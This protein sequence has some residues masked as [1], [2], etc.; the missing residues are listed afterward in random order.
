[1]T[2]MGLDWVRAWSVL[3]TMSEV[4]LV[5]VC[6]ACEGTL[7]VPPRHL[8]ATGTC[9]KCGVR[10]ALI[11]RA[12]GDTPQRASLVA[13]AVEDDTRIPATEKQLTYL[14]ALGARPEALTGLTRSR[15]SALIEAGKQRRQ[16]GEPATERQRAYLAK[17]GADPE[18][19]RRA[20]TK[21]AASALIEDMH[22]HPT[23]PQVDR[24]REL[25]ATGAQ[26]AALKSRGEVRALLLR[27]GD[28]A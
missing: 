21:A 28:E 7:R 18:L 9:N 23:R 3:P 20:A 1:M 10:I 22:L 11:G 27:L 13:D 26:I 16:A 24:L 8:G 12:E 17:L 2:A 19:V 5:F 25:G 14:R 15:A 6:P 4:I